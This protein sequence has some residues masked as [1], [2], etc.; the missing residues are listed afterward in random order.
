MFKLVF[1]WRTL[2]FAQYVED[3]LCMHKN[4][5]DMD[6]Y[7]NERPIR[8]WFVNTV[9][10][11]KVRQRF[12]ISTVALPATLTTGKPAIY[13]KKEEKSNLSLS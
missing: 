11:S 7:G 2:L 4:F 8:R 13:L 3:F 6:R 5:R 9:C 12:G 10:S 1:S